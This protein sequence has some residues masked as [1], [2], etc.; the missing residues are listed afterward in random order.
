MG[1][2]E[3]GDK[4]EANEGERKALLV[5]FLIVLFREVVAGT[6]AVIFLV[7]SVFVVAMSI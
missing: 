4:E 2:T 7:V 1:A 6:A 5:L 3:G